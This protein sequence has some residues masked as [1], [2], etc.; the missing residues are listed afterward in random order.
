MMTQLN[1]IPPVITL[2]WIFLVPNA[3][4]DAPPHEILSVTYNSRSITVQPHTFDS[5]TSPILSPRGACGEGF[6]GFT[7]N[8]ALGRPLPYIS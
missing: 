5:H 8:K 3:L 2:E 7:P 1:F 6:L 4:V